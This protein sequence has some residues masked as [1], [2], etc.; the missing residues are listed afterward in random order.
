MILMIVLLVVFTLI[1]QSFAQERSKIIVQGSGFEITLE[2]KDYRFKDKKKDHFTIRDYIEFTNESKS[3]AFKLPSR[4][5]IVAIPPESKV[6]VAFL[7]AT[8]IKYNNILPALNPEV[9]MIDDSTYVLKE[10]EYSDRRINYYRADRIE[11]KGYFWLREFYCIHLKIHTHSY[12]EKSS[13]LTELSDIKLKFNFENDVKILPYSPLEIKSPFDENLRLILANTE[14]AEQFRDNPKLLLNDT[15]G[16]WINYFSNYLKIG[17]A[18]DGIYRITRNDLI[19]WGVNLVGINPKTFQLFESG[20]E[21]PIYVLG[22]SDFSFDNGDYIEFYGTKNYSKI[23]PRVINPDKQPYNN[24]LDKYTDTAFYF[25]TWDATNGKRAKENTTYQP[26]IPDSL[27]YYTSFIH[28][29]KNEMDA[30]FYTFHNDLVES[31]FP[32]WD[33]G[34]GW[35]QQWLATWATPVNFTISAADIVPNKTAK[36]YGKIVSRASSGST[37]VHRVK[38]LINGTMIDS[39]VTSRFQRVLLQGSINSSSVISG[40][41]TLGISYEEANGASG[42]QMLVDWAEAEY[43]RL[44]KLTNNSLY[45]EYKDLTNTAL[46]KIKIENVLTSNYLLFKVKPEFQRITGFELTG[47][48]LYFT[49]TVSNNDAYYLVRQDIAS[50]PK[51]FSLKTFENLRSQTNQVDYLGI[52]HPNFLASVNDYVNF[53]SSNYSVTSGVYSVE[54]I[55]DEFGY[56]YPIAD[57]I[58]NFIIYRF[59]SAPTPK[60]SYLVLF[61]DANY[62]YKKY[63]TASQGIVGGG[64]FVPSYGFPIS[65]PFYTVW[66]STGAR[67]PQMYVGRIPLN[68]NSEMVFYKSK[69][70][71]NLTI[72][73]DDWNKRYL[74]FSG[75]RA[76]F[77]SEIALYKSIN[78]SVINN[79]VK[80]PPLAGSYYHF[81]K[82]TNPLSDFGPYTSTVVNNAIEAGGVFISYIGHSGTATWD[83]SISSVRQLKNKINRNPII[84]DFGCST[85]KFGE[86]DLVAFGERFVLDPDGQALGYIGNSALGFV[87]TAIKAPGNFYKN[88]IQD[89]IFQV[90]KAHLSAKYL[91]FQQLGSS[92]VVNEFS[93]SNTLMGDPILKMKIP[94]K[95]NLKISSDDILYET[96]LITDALDSIKI[97]IV[98]NNL[99]TVVPQTFKAALTHSYQSSVVEY[100]EKIL[101]LPNFK[102]TIS[103]WVQIKNK[104]GQHSL[105]VYLDSE[106]SISEIY[107]NDNDVLVNFNVASST[108]RDLFINRFENPNLDSLIILNPSTR[109]EKAPII[110]FQL[111]DNENFSNYQPYN[112]T[113]DTFSTKISFQTPINNNRSWLRYKIDDGVEWSSPLT[114]TK[115]SGSK[116]YL[117]DLYSWGKQNL[118]SLR[119]VNDTVRLSID[120]VIISIISAGSYSGQYCII[121]KNGINLLSNTFFQGIGIVVFNEKTLVVESSTYY[122]LFNNPAGVI[123]CTNFIN[124]IPSGKLVALGVSGDAKNN[125]TTALSNAVIS[126]GGTLFPSIQFKAPYALIGGKGINPAL[127]K[128]ILK[129]PFEGPIQLDT[130][131]VKSLESGVLVSTQ[132]GPSSEWKKLKVT[133]V[134]QN[135]SEI[136]FRAIG[137]K[138]DG[139]VDTLP[140]LNL[141]SNE[142]NLNSIS[143]TTYPFIKIRA[144]LKADSLLNSPQ[145]SKL[146]VD[147]KGIAELGTNFQA[148]KLNKDTVDQ[149]E[150]SRLNF[151]VYNAGEAKA[152]NFMVQV[153]V[154]RPDNSSE[155]VLEQFIDSIGPGQRKLLGTGFI[156][157]F[158][159]GDREYKINIDPLDQVLEYYNDNNIFYQPFYI[160]RDTTRPVIHVLFNGQEIVDGDYVPSNPLIRIELTDPS[161]LR[162]YNANSVSIKMDDQSAAL[163]K[164]AAQLSYEF[165]E[166]NPKLVVEY[167]PILEEGEHTLKI[168]ANDGLGN[169]ADTSALQKRFIVSNSTA[170]S[171][172][173]N[174]PNPI[175]ENTN[176]TFELAPNLPYEVRILVYTISGRLVKKLIIPQGDLRPNFNKIYWDTRDEDGDLLGN[177]TYLYKVIMEADD[178]TETSVHKLAIV[179]Q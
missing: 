81:Y 89:T 100:L 151:Y 33:T 137:V 157:E 152:N 155:I 12:D 26:S 58:R 178:K 9:E 124:S 111:A 47:G 70:Q 76:D 117:G 65:D 174:F 125:L 149:G 143:A 139:T 59:Q 64:N 144:E 67:L 171:N 52:S 29:E 97:N 120:T 99:G 147:Y 110:N 36:F 173:Y 127:I 133:Q 17:I 175:S 114:Y 27:T 3:G 68:K 128:Q 34:K 123:A 132:I 131:I 16:N 103:F 74:F 140:Y 23:S 104:P 141:V 88:V 106:N 135:N 164:N 108:I 172:V 49:D 40:N 15:T 35:Y 169:L 79:F 167:K 7:S 156:T 159:A 129:T 51:F 44:L 136:K 138:L 77:P 153:E 160:R 83:N 92:N 84:S 71:N 61:G 101:S 45:F 63:R 73:F 42:G 107:E 25:L 119:I 56:G 18:N 10:V 90:G 72:P 162:N 126:L 163:E 53:I 109:S 66:D 82:T 38:L 113:I 168:F 21:K 22:E 102:D 95:P 170:I 48:N 69:V 55:Y 179:R 96:S 11:T 121:S 62:D 105:Q 122:E 20:V 130:A 177:G 54:D 87:S 112:F 148:V 118:S 31:Q 57:A 14:I 32:F 13:T 24:Y 146:E 8:E 2:N 50:T 116:Y 93:F 85:N 30:L 5:L 4:D 1:N 94:S 39:Q 41:N 46:K 80:V 145:L 75:G 161:T 86:P 6:N 98:L 176:F 165:N 91:M 142:A 37:N 158:E 154:N 60:P 115:S 134:N 166:N 150:K 28:S 19:N 78:D 43:P